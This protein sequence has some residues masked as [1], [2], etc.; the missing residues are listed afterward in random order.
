M[1]HVLNVAYGVANPF[2]DQ[3]LYK[4]VQILDLPEMDVTSYVKECGSFIEQA[5]EQVRAENS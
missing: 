1:S 3:L 4:T 5:R 2:P